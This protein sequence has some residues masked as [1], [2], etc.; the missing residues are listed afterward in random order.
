MLEVHDHSPACEPSVNRP[1]HAQF[2]PHVSPRACERLCANLCWTGMA[3]DA[4]RCPYWLCRLQPEYP[5]QFARS[6]VRARGRNASG[7]RDSCERTAWSPSRPERGHIDPR[8]RPTMRGRRYGAGDDRETG[9]TAPTSR[10]R[11]R[12][13]GRSSPFYRARLNSRC[14]AKTTGRSI[15]FP[16]CCMTPL[17]SAP[18]HASRMRRA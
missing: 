12:D 18:S 8:L 9:L 15:I 2:R 6:F 4:F 14:A 16:S 11:P 17:S 13:S 5:G 7:A 1:W 10:L 3:A